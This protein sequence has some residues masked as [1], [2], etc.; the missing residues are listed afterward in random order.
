MGKRKEQQQQNN[1]TPEFYSTY[2][3]HNKELSEYET[4]K[5]EVF[6]FFQVDVII[7]NTATVNNPSV[8]STA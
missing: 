5:F 3:E 4:S 6:S 2:K 1:G 8:S 7:N